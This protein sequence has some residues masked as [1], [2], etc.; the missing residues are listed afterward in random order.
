MNHL[1]SVDIYLRFFVAFGLILVL[2]G[3]AAWMARFLGFSTPLKA[4]G[5][6]QRRLGVADVIAIDARRRLVLVSRDDVEHLIC[7]G[8]TSDFVV[9][10]D[11]KSAL[12]AINQDL[13][14]QINESIEENKVSH[15]A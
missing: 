3:A 15:E 1:S 6:K 12:P 11:I 10:A 9:E 14:T 7:I 4:R 5:H 2:I 8:G 13:V